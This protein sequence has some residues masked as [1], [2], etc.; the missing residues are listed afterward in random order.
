MKRE[1]GFS[2]VELLMVVSILGILASMAVMNMWRSRAVANETSAIMSMRSISS[3]QIAYSATCGGG[4]FATT[5]PFLGPQ[6]STTQGFLSPDLTGA[7]VVQKSGYTIRLA[8]SAASV[9]G[10]NDC[11]G[12]PSQ[13]G[14]YASAEPTTFGATGNRSF[15]TLSP[16]NAIWQDFSAN[17]PTEPFTLPATPIR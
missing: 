13:T 2:L 5:L 9:P 10:P 4:R 6:V 11:N 15:A 1:S 16:M 12:N 3:A 8:P 7:V 14:F 17:A